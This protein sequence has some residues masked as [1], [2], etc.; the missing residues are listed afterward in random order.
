M[1]PKLKIDHFNFK[2]SR[3][4]MKVKVAASQLSYSVAACVQTWI[5]SGNLPSEAAHTAEFVHKIDS[6]FDSLNGNSFAI[7][8]DYLKLDLILLFF[9]FPQVQEVDSWQLYTWVTVNSIIREEAVY[10]STPRK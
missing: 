8:E 4:N 1:L 10:F 5:A 7:P 6:L 9:A 2:D 3:L